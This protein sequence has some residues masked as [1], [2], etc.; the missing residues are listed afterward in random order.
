MWKFDPLQEFGA[1]KGN[2]LLVSVLEHR[3]FGVRQFVSR[4]RVHSL[5]KS[6][7]GG[8]ILCV[9]DDVRL[10]AIV[11]LDQSGVAVRSSEAGLTAE[12]F[13]AQRGGYPIEKASSAR[14][15]NISAS[16]S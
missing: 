3:D 5:P 7:R 10:P 13:E 15:V 8:R 2:A 6:C 4:H 1:R 9:N 12:W 11:H 14:A 16:A